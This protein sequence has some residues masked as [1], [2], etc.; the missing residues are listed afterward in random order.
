MAV[1]S[2]AHTHHDPEM[3][4][5]E[6]RRHA[7]AEYAYEEVADNSG[8]SSESELTTADPAHKQPQANCGGGHDAVVMSC[9]E[10]KMRQDIGKQTILSPENAYLWSKT[11]L[12]YRSFSSQVER[13]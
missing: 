4:Q 9:P 8:L 5:G 1:H 6:T 3:K 11:S 2:Q 12:L 10:S 7:G 13:L